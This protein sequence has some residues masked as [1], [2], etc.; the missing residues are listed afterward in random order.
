MRK[1]LT[2]IR[3][4]KLKEGTLLSFSDDFRR[5]WV[6]IL[7]FNDW[8]GYPSFNP[9]PPQDEE[10]WDIREWNYYSVCTK[11]DFVLWKLE[12]A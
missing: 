8:D 7:T 6:G 11:K 10:P 5:T 3:G 2:K 1:P 4:L 12:N 9:I